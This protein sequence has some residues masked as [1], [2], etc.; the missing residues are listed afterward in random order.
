MCTQ[1]FLQ[2]IKFLRLKIMCV[3]VSYKKNMK[4]I[5]FFFILEVTEERSRIRI[6]SSEERIQNVTD[7]QHWIRQSSYFKIFYK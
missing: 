4:K 1:H 6:H 5:N 7:P 3:W 2:K